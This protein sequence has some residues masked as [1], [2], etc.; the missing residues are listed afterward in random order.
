VFLLLPPPLLH[1][2]H[3]KRNRS[4]LTALNMLLAISEQSAGP[5]V[6]APN[7]LDFDMK[8]RSKSNA[9][10]KKPIS[11]PGSI[12]QV[13]VPTLLWSLVMAL[14]SVLEVSISVGRT[15]VLIVVPREIWLLCNMLMNSTPQ[16]NNRFPFHLITFS[17]QDPVL[18]FVSEVQNIRC[19]EPNCPA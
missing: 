11:P 8:H 2:C 19:L 15:M 13:I 17:R 7:S 4:V 18:M 6:I 5:N 14:S 16:P 3:V 9:Y 10:R 12:A 1:P